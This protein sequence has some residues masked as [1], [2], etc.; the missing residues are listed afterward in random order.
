MPHLPDHLLIALI[1][2]VYP[3]YSTLTWY[4]RARSQMETGGSGSR[5]R[6]YREAMLELWLLTAAVLAWWLPAGRTIA[7]I[8][9]GVPGGWRFWVGAIVFV[10]F[11]TILGRQTATVRASA[12]ARDQVRSQLEGQFGAGAILMIPRNDAERRTWVGLSLTAGICEEILY[13]AFFI[14]YLTAWLPTAAAVAVSS[15][16]FG[17]AHLYLGWGGV[18]RATATGAVLA[19]AYLVT[20]SLWVPMALHAT[21]DITSGFTGNAALY[22]G[23]TETR[24]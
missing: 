5:R 12:E 20:G 19:L 9:L 24:S 21:V 17:A 8:G 15:V 14:W 22:P 1:A 11:A 13:R 18:V 7:E 23:A 6:Y 10:A 4:R 2:V 3:V 16:V